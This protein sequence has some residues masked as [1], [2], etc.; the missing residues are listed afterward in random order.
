MSPD[1]SWDDTSINDTSIYDT[2]INDTS[3]ND[4]PLYPPTADAEPEGRDEHDESDEWPA[5]TH[6]KG[7]RVRIPVALLLLGVVA[8]LGI[9]GGAKLATNNTASVATGTGT[10][11]AA[12]GAGGQ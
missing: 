1:T 2:S 6:A 7:V 12:A 5:A 3:I 10:L 11:G 4:L 9:W 8:A